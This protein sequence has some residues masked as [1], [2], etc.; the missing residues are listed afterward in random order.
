LLPKQIREWFGS[1]QTTI[2]SSPTKT[3]LWILRVLFI[4]LVV[5]LASRVFS[6]ED[7]Y[8]SFFAILGIALAVIAGDVLTHN[9]EISTISAV[10]FG[11][12]LG[13]LLATLFWNALEPIIN[14]Y[15]PTQVLQLVRL[16]MTLITCYISVSILVQTKDEF[17]FIIPYVEFS[18]Q[19]KGAKPLVLDTSVIIDG[20]IADICDTGVHRHQDDRAALRAAGAAE[21]WRTAPTSSSATAAGAGW[22]C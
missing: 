18:R 11:L 1:S 16:F 21:G 6:I 17:R 9:K 8:T 5:G 14:A 2:F 3:L 13:F 19:L 15:F 20:R 12:L 10:Y 22:T 4:V 7:N